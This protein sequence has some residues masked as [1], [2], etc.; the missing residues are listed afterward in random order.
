MVIYRLDYLL[1]EDGVNQI[2]RDWPRAREF[3]GLDLSYQCSSKQIGEHVYEYWRQT[4]VVKS[5]WFC[6]NR[7]AVVRR[8]ELFKAN[9]LY[10]KKSDHMIHMVEMP[11]RKKEIVAWL[12][13][14]GI[15]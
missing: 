4:G 10:G 12:N 6:S 5:E 8:L 11:T 2:F 1:A 14:R 15:K 7:E 13:E 3:L 9:K